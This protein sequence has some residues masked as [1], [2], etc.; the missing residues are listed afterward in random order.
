MNSSRLLSIDV[1]TQSARAIVFDARGQLL[2]KA[3][4]IFEPTYRSPQP[5]WAEQDPEVYW[6]A[7]VRCCQRLWVQGEVR[8]E[9]I[10][11]IS[12]TTQRATMVCVGADGE[13]LRPAIVWLDQRRCTDPPKLSALWR[14]VF[15]MIGATPLIEHLQREA[16]ANW[17]AQHEP[18]L[19]R[20]TTHFLLLSGWLTHRMVGEYV[21]STGCQVGFIPFDYRRH[22]WAAPGDFKWQALAVRREQLP[23]LRPPGSVLGT[24]TADA[25]RVLGLPVGVPLIAAAADK[26]CEVLGS[27]VLEPDVAQLSFGTTATINTT[28]ARYLE[29]Q[30]MLPPYPAALPGAYNTEIQIYRGFWMVSWFKREFAHREQA[31]A[32]ERGVAVEDLFDELIG[33]VPPG[34]MGL[35]LQP[36]WSP[37][38]RDPGPE[39]KGA[40]IGFGDVH[41]RAHFYRAILEGLIYGLRGGSEQIQKRSGQPIRLLRVAGGGSQSD[42]AMQITADVFGLPA[43]RPSIYETS[44][45]G[46]AINAAVGLGIYPDYATAVQAMTRV[47]ARFEPRPEAVA[48]YDALYREVYGRMYGRLRPLY[49]AIRR[50]TG[51]P[52]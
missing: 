6:A 30:R 1:G 22:D 19:W 33:H 28:Q 41:T 45:L 14:G 49:H 37:G 20:H 52:P 50:I 12:L 31:L 25:A 40:I 46:A 39:A 3:Q 29:V 47:G 17:L 43:E 38:V 32:A 5:G 48:V 15:R 10:S 23:S 27:G 35:M 36:Y 42:Q 13:V 9:Q 2:R 44:A 21:D 34:S 26:A 7:V 4:E 18:E 8:P 11:A 16:D 51:Y 24:L